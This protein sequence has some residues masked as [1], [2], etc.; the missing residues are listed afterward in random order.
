MQP[1][2]FG[3]FSRADLA[4]TLLGALIEAGAAP[5]DLSL[6]VRR[7]GV[8]STDKLEELTSGNEL[9]ES[10]E[11]EP[12]FYGHAA[13]Q[14]EGSDIYESEIGGGIGTST[15]DDDVSSVEEMDDSQSA[16]ES[17]SYPANGHSYSDEEERDA[18][19]ATNTGFF[20]LTDT[21]PNGLGLV[22]PEGDSHQKLP[23]ELSSLLLPHFGLVLGDGTLATELMGA[24][25][26]ATVGGDPAARLQDYL[27]D[28]AVPH[29]LAFMLAKDF[30]GGGAVVAIATPPGGLD[31]DEIQRILEQ[32]GAK[33][34]KTVDAAD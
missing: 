14:T 11:G 34:V 21:G 25:I 4:E 28:Q 3:S 24:G 13:I 1:T 17:M 2:V 26:A 23:S 16:S 29:D 7:N 30:E 6:V 15:P 33:N 8:P 22:D 27:E 10:G 9:I 19:K 32:T 20:H 12:A 31:V 18:L 5:E